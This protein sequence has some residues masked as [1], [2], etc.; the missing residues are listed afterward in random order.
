[1]TISESWHYFSD[2]GNKELNDGYEV[3]VEAYGK[4]CS[5]ISQL[6]HQLIFDNYEWHGLL[7]RRLYGN[8]VI[9]W[10]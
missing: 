7:L 1:M 2:G 8:R 6:P 10:N 5:L 3:L 9:K 4:I